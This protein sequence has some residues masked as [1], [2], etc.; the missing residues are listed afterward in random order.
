MLFLW[1]PVNDLKHTV[2]LTH[3][4]IRFHLISPLLSLHYQITESAV[5][6]TWQY[7]E[8]FVN[9]YCHHIVVFYYNATICLANV[10]VDYYIAKGVNAWSNSD[11]YE[12][13]FHRLCLLQYHAQNKVV[14]IN[15]IGFY[16]EMFLRLSISYSFWLF[17]RTFLPPPMF[18]T[19]MFLLYLP[20]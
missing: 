16:L 8:T 6:R 4:F 17:G 2:Q 11:C 19:V 3:W 20:N 7:C 12:C 14:S 13:L 1:W 15:K 5:N 10:C 9:T 18:V